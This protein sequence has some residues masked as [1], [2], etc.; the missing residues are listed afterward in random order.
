MH[1]IKSAA[2]KAAALSHARKQLRAI[3]GSDSVTVNCGSVDFKGQIAYA[4]WSMSADRSMVAS[5][6]INYPAMPDNS[7]LTRR[8]A[9]LISAYT[10][11]EV[12]HVA[13]TNNL[14]VRGVGHLLRMVW[15]GIEDARIEHAV[16]SSGRANGARSGF[17][18]LVSSMTAKLSD[19]FNPTNI[20]SAPFALA[21]I[22]RAAYGDGNG[23]A[24]TLLDRIPEPKRSI[25]K[26]A[27]DGVVKLPLDRSGTVGA[28]A[29]AREF[30]ESWSRIEPIDSDKPEQQ[31]TKQPEQSPDFDDESDDQDG[32][33]SSGEE[34]LEEGDEDELSS[35][36]EEADAGEVSSNGSLDQ[37]DSQDEQSES[38]EGGD[39]AS[40]MFA[41]NQEKY[42]EELCKSPEPS[43]DEVFDRVRSRVPYG[44]TLP[45]TPKV[46][47]TRMSQW[48]SIKQKQAD[49]S[50]V[51][52]AFRKLSKGSLPAL[53]ARLYQVLKSP[54]RVG[55][56]GG[57]IGGRFDARRAPRMMAGSE[58]VFKRRW[59]SE[60]VETAVTVLVDMSG[61]MS[62]VRSKD[63]A[64]LAWTIAQAAES[65]GAK[66]EVA[67][68]RNPTHYDY[69]IRNSGYNMFG[70]FNSGTGYDG[71]HGVLVV[72][73]QFNERCASVP[74]NFA[75]MP[76]L[77]SGGTPDYTCLRAAVDRLSTVD[78]NRRIVIVITDGIGERSK[79]KLMTCVSKN[80]F[81]VEIV[82][83]GIGT[84]DESLSEAYNIGAAVHTS[85]DLAAV[86]LKKIIK[87]LKASDHRRV[88]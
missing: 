31:P 86:A 14:D 36:E 7:W 9:D 64:D 2:V 57:S 74:L 38:G 65:A 78:A 39:G 32:G 28:M 24:K 81:D 79:V 63:A 54:E 68:F 58:A 80:L 34:G 49:E 8:D 41:D 40:D 85:H 71:Q 11:H 22:C 27:A 43:I 75:K 17:K 56:D 72:A 70:E 61:S 69:T 30:I 5:F 12:G 3:I 50:A 13:F 10:N 15:N 18:Q 19:S 16:A 47:V 44:I 45:V 88:A 51:R 53:K 37:V 55:W 77:S 35:T 52:R 21:L 60:G 62:G 73:K 67:G 59:L 1:K 6:H 48:A 25:Y 20:N 33:Q 82:A 23:Y 26:A 87:Q 84:S 42:S 76:S 29:L 66:V 46:T 4:Q 83:F